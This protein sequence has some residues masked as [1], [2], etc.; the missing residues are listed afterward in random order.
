MFGEYEEARVALGVAG[1]NGTSQQRRNPQNFEK[2][3]RDMSDVELER[4][5]GARQVQGRLVLV[6]RGDAIEAARG[7][8]PVEEGRR[9]GGVGRALGPETFPHHH[10][11]VFVRERQRLHQDLPGDI[12]D[13]GVRSDPEGQREHHHQG[14]RRGHTER[15]KGVDQ[16]LKH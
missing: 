2:L 1:Q 3:L 12:E 13:G 16:V 8:L 15:T 9:C 4:F 10:Q 7:A 11:T 5:S 6:E 14:V